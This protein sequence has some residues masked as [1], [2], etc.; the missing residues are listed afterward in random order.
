MPTFAVRRARYEPDARSNVGSQ[1]GAMMTYGE[2]E[3]DIRRA[4]RA[5]MRR[6][7]PIALLASLLASVADAASLARQCRVACR[8][9]IAACVIG[10]RPTGGCVKKLLIVAAMVA[11]AAGT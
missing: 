5:T 10:R 6:A 9:E 7:L 11:S 8:D 4:T 3:S 1:R 2:S